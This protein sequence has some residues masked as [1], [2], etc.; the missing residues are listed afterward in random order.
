MPQ[1]QVT[2]EEKEVYR[3]EIYNP[4]KLPWDKIREDILKIEESAYG[5]EDLFGEEVLQNDFEDPDNIVVILRDIATEKIIGFTY[6]KPTLKSYPEDFP[7]REMSKDT[8]Y[9]Y[10]TVIE[11]SYQGKGL[12]SSL[13]NKLEDELVRRGFSFVERDAA[14]DREGE[15]SGAETY[16][17]KLRK[18]YQERIL[19][20]EAHDSEFGPQVFFRMS[21]PKPEKESMNV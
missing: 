19:K 16:A 18:N 9:I 7:E 1:E 20:E 2:R 10:Y 5:E 15:Q 14:N 11:K 17:D 8:A 6:A 12:V 13:L 4:D 3:P 21:L